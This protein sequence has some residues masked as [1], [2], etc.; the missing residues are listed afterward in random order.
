MA[1]SWCF[2]E[3]CFRLPTAGHPEFYVRP[4]PDALHCAQLRRNPRIV[5]LLRELPDV[6]HLR[7]PWSGHRIPSI[8]CQRK[9]RRLCIRMEFSKAWVSPHAERVK[10]RHGHFLEH[11]FRQVPANHDIPQRR[12]ACL[13]CAAGD[14]T[15]SCEPLPVSKLTPVLQNHGRRIISAVISD[16]D[17]HTRRKPGPRWPSQEPL[18]VL[19]SAA[20]L[21][22]IQQCAPFACQLR[23]RR[24]TNA[25]R[26][27]LRRPGK[28]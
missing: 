13:C 8:E 5:L 6:P 1:G 20:Y 11:V 26:P 24:Q 19:L 15:C 7:P 3:A 21:E 16:T 9:Q 28:A 17:R 4:S 25:W 10:S 23:L 18:V 2:H 22:L 14:S 27:R 12:D